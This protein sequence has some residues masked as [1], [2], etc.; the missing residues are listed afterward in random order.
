MDEGPVLVT[1]AI[2]IK[3]GR[4]LI[5]KRHDGAT[6]E[7]GKWEFPGGK[8]DFGEHPE[9]TIEREIREELG[10]EVEVLRLHRVDTCV[11]SVPG[12]N[13]HVVILFY[14]CRIMS[15]DPRPLDCQELKWIERRELKDHVFVRGDL[16]FIEE[17]MSD[18]RPL[19]G[20]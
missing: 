5:A 9:D 16:A 18:D 14:I 15:G 20:A 19:P 13:R 3:D 1:S 12:R 2:I 4:L 6:F 7:P 10:M 8:V 11:Y 17:L